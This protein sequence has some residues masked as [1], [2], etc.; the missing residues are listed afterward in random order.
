MN[1]PI[2]TY[3]IISF[4]LALVFL[5]IS[6]VLL[7]KIF[8]KRYSN[9]SKWISILV[10]IISYITIYN[11][12]TIEHIYFL[13]CGMLALG[14]LLSV[15]AAKVI[16]DDEKYKYIKAGIMIIIAVFCYQGSIA[17]FPMIV[18]TYK[19]LFQNNSLKKDFIDVVKIVIIYGISMLLTILF[20]ELLM[21]GSRIQMDLNQFDISN[22]L[23][24]LNELVVNSLGVIFPYLNIG[25]IVLTILV[26]LMKKGTNGKEKAFYI[27]KYLLIILASIV[28]CIIPIVVGSGLE[29]TPR[30]CIAYGSTIGLSLFTMLLIVH[31][32]DKKYQLV[33]ISIITIIVFIF[34]FSLYVILTR[35]HL[36]VNKLD[37]ANCE[38]VKEV[39]EKYEAETNI[40]V[41]RIAGC[42]KEEYMYYPGFSHAGAITQKALNSW[43]LRETICYYIGRH[44]DYAPITEEQY[45]EFFAGKKWEE[46]STEQ[47]VIEDGVLYFCGG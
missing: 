7:Y 19:L 39:V 12:L 9:S 38:I 36:E 11:Y 10:I 14:I 29:L 1:L 41:T 37:K 3:M 46:F 31:K 26:I 2:E 16:I 34:N 24:W 20:A 13:E 17:I 27:L 25:F 33:I 4:I 8:I 35:Q 5:S 15:I 30:M 6:V 45:A 28:I 42:S 47:I 18:L 43:A 44:L 22:I 40:E 32:N 21:G 23:Y